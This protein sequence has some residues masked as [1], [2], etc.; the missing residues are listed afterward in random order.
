VR[1]WIPGFLIGNVR[2]W[3]PGFL[4]GNV[5]SRLP[6]RVGAGHRHLAAFTLAILTFAPLQLPAASP[7]PV[8]APNGAVV[9]SSRLASEA[10]N[11]IMVQGGN[12]VDAAV[13]TFFALAVTLPQAGNIGGGGFAVVHLAS[14]EEFTLDFREKA[15]A[16]ADRDMF[17]DENGE[18]VEE[19]SLETLL[20][21]GVPG[22]VD[23]ALRFY[24]DPGSGK[25]TR[26]QVL[27]PAIELAR[28][29]FPI[30]RYFAAQL[31]DLKE[32]FSKS[33]GA[34]GIFVRSD[35][36]LWRAGDVLVQSD[37]ANTLETIANKGRD[38][39]YDGRVAKLIVAE[40]QRGNGIITRDDLRQYR[41]VYRE[42]VRGRF[43]GRDVLS[44]GPPSSGG[45]HLIQ[46][47]NMLD[48]L[49]VEKEVWHSSEYVHLLTEVERRAYADRAEH[50]GDMD[51]WDVPVE[52]LTSVEYAKRRIADISRTRATPSTEVA[53]G[54]IPLPDGENTTHF[55]VADTHGN[56]VAITTTINPY[57]YTCG[58]VVDGGGFFLN[59]E[60]VDF[61][62]K[63]GVPDYFGLL[64][65]EA[66]AIA[67]HKRML[68]A[69]TP[70]IVLS[71]GK[72]LII[73]GSPGGGT[74]ITTVMQVILNVLVND[75]NIQEAVLAPRVHSQWFP[76]TIQIET[77]ALSEDTIE[78]LEEM[79]HEVVPRGNIIGR[80]HCI[81]FGED[82]LYVAPDHRFSDTSIVGAD[83]RRV[84]SLAAVH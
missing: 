1:S 64:G 31:N 29:G 78:A 75:M 71:E 27:T 36:R 59:N 3:I 30:S 56:A 60:M 22:S 46:M 16:A 81:Y 24:D 38:G 8:F 83:R 52:T 72:P 37:L 76:D 19:L 50:L 41:S 73:V 79:G 26:R 4:I 11:S 20:G 34:A 35:G 58:I 68:S 7:E 74:I 18:V 66:N 9:S 13:A 55:S 45:I 80:A 40:M 48:L 6:Y 57:F 39:F 47:L 67:P 77:Y 14:G 12:A 49:G 84:D 23:G 70:T 15:P 61:V 5:R 10:G 62:H 2:S 21:V 82:G 44:M 32:L 33:P 17:L 28:D 51:F 69:M 63:P 42:P 53:A 25:V 65:N 43:K 54:R